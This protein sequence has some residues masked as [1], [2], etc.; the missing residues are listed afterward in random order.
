MAA[1]RHYITSGPGKW[2]FV[3]GTFDK[4]RPIFFT[5]TG[6]TDVSKVQVDIR[7]VG[8]ED[9]TREKWLFSG[10]LIGP[11]QLVDGRPRP[12]HGYYNLRE[13]SGWIELPR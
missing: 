10:I 3:V 8:M 13:R 11:D 2:D 5:V 12:C 9:G 7:S 4:E 1:Q 6:V